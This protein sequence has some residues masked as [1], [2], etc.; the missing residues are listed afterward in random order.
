MEKSNLELSNIE[1]ALTNETESECTLNAIE[2]SSNEEKDN[3]SKTLSILYSIVMMAL[4][5]Y[6]FRRHSRSWKK[7]T[8]AVGGALYLLVRSSPS[9]SAREWFNIWTFMTSFSLYSYQKPEFSRQYFFLTQ[10]PFIFVEVP[11]DET[12]SF[13]SKYLF[14]KALTVIA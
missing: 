1:T 4:T 2:D 11:L 6:M 9:P 5:A 7:W 8:I 10:S 3:R 12:L 14:W 13:C